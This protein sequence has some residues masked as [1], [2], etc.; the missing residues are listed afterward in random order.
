MYKQVQMS[1]NEKAQHPRSTAQPEMT[2]PV[3][4]GHNKLHSLDQTETKYNPG[5]TRA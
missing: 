4:I 3:K 5:V 1:A 2:S